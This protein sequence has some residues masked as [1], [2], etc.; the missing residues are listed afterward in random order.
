[1]ER[2]VNFA[3]MSGWLVGLNVEVSLSLQPITIYTSAAFIN[4]TLGIS[5]TYGIR[6]RRILN[7]VPSD[8][9]PRYGVTE[10]TRSSAI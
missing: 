3:C 2:R 6:C 5:P 7:P 10:R 1:M 9:G 4:K 8:G